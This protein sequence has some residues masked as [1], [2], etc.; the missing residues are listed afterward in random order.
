MLV[1]VSNDWVCSI[2]CVCSLV[3]CICFVL[4]DRLF[5][6]R[7]NV[8]FSRVKVMIILSRVKLCVCCF[9]VFVRGWS[10]FCW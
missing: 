6:S 3:L 4:L 7:V 10:G 1:L 2:V 5:S 8:R 9:I